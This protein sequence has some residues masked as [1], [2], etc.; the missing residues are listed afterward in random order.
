MRPLLKRLVSPIFNSFSGFWPSN[1]WILPSVQW[2]LWASCAHSWCTSP[3]RTDHFGVAE[4]R[5]TRPPKLVCAGYGSRFHS[6]A[7]SSCAA[8]DW[9]SPR[10]GSADS[11]CPCQR[12]WYAILCRVEKYLRRR[13]DPRKRIGLH[14][15]EGD[16]GRGVGVQ[17]GHGVAHESALRVREHHRV[18]EY[19]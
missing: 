1:S 12:R 8:D 19:R 3:K 13:T 6:W 11:V 15:H 16:L 7:Y 5:E 4:A 10:C 9:A 2:R 18:V 14:E 17:V